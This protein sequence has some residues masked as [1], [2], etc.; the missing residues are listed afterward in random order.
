VGPSDNI[1]SRIGGPGSVLC[2]AAGTYK[3]AITISNSGTADKR[4]TVKAAPDAHVILDGGNSL[5][6]DRWGAMVHVAGNYVTVDGFEIVN[7]FG[8]GVHVEGH[9]GTVRNMV[10]HDTWGSAIMAMGDDPLIEG[11]HAYRTVLQNKNGASGS[12]GWGSSIATGRDRINGITERG[13]MR[14]NI[15]HDNWGEGINSFSSAGTLIEGNIVYNNYSVNLYISD[16]PNTIARNNLVYDVATQNGGDLTVA[17]EGVGADAGKP[18]SANV[19]V[20]NNIVYG[21]NLCEVCWTIRKGLKNI[22]FHHNTV[23]NGQFVID[24]SNGTGIVYS[25]N[26]VIPASKVPGLGTV[27]P[28]SLTPQKFANAECPAGTGADVSKF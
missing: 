22:N 4:I 11:N 18:S 25:A 5:P 12:S 19:Q 8:Y 24:T 10:I 1:N 7:S 28:G 17:D 21:T 23:V 15:S 14:N 20:Y 2:L 27:T 13:I 26:C 16:S 6:G 3:Q 9:H